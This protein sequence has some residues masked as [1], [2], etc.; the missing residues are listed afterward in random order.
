V[1]L[2]ALI[3][4]AVG[5]KAADADK[6]EIAALGALFGSDQADLSSIEY[7]KQLLDISLG[8]IKQ[9]P[10]FGVPDY[11]AQM[12]S[13]KQGE[14]I[15]DIVNSYVGIMLDAGVVGLAI[16]LLPF[17]VVVNRLVGA[18][19]RGIDGR[20]E[21]GSRFAFAFVGLILGCLLAILT[22]SSWSLMPMLLTI[23]IALP[24]AWL[25][26]PADER[27]AEG[28]RADLEL[29]LPEDPLRRRPTWNG[30]AIS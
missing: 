25:G 23:A 16:Y 24:T 22:T 20:H 8:L 19:R 4:G 9:S 26:L 14:G 30:G 1:A 6:T 29:D 18:A 17:I 15:I 13:L 10:W 12:Q 2:V 5:L 27:N 7:R 3:L 28:A 11:A 21:P